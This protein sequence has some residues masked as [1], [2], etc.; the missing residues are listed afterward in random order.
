MATK[1]TGS[2]SFT[3][4][5][6]F[7]PK[8]FHGGL[9]FALLSIGY[10]S[11]CVSLLGDALQGN[12]I[13]VTAVENPSEP[14]G[15]SP[16][17]SVGVKK[18]ADSPVLQPARFEASQKQSTKI[19]QSSS[20]AKDANAASN[21]P[22]LERAP[23]PKR[24]APQRETL[25]ID[26]VTA[27][28]LVDTSNPTIA[29]ARARVVEAEQRLREVE[30]AWL[31][32]LQT[33]PAYV[34]HDGQ[35]QNSRGEV[36][37]VS[38]SNF[39]EGG[40][41]T[42]RWETANLYFGPLIAR[43]LVQAQDA[44]SRAVSSEIQL[45]VASAYLDLMRV[46]GTL[47]INTDTLARAGEMLN[48]AEAGEA[49]GKSKT[50]ADI[51]RA[52]T[53]VELRRQ[54]RI[55]IRG[56]AAVVSARLARLLLLEP[57]VDLR[58][59]DPKIVPVALLPDDSLIEEL[60]ATGLLNRP[61]L[62]ESRALVEAAVARWRQARVTPFVPRIEV[63][64]SGGLFGGGVNEVLSNFS[65]RSDGLAQAVWELHNL[66][67]GDITRA[68]QRR[69]QLTEASL[70]VRE[71][72]AQVAEEVTAAAKLV[73]TRREALDSSQKSV[74]EALETWRRLKEAS[75]GFGV[76]G[77]YDPLEPLLAEQALDQARNRYLTQVIEYN[78]AQFRLYWAMGQPPESALPKASALP[79][80]VP[81]VPGKP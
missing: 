75:F 78:R 31:P 1:Q 54:E 72:E 71:V 6:A 34:R 52:R 22:T 25:P 61:E 68:R 15:V 28:R 17:S 64:Y 58:P 42:L 13:L 26:L 65:G 32:D 10:S 46:Y 40:G 19:E 69:T 60:V 79:I 81:V 33:G 44:A 2:N 43:Q 37:G 5:S 62:A 23:A 30:V 35:L 76:G 50:P 66:G 57:T 11:G 80:N 14:V 41:A 63:T 67:A 24:G 45:E 74:T 55:E 36:F 27:L 48:S 12:N 16:I 49:A 18:R 73:E 38:K 77:K 56:Q 53:E 39:F 20:P 9:L 47:A 70:H 29:L 8:P 4:R 3:G 7:L 51:N 59:A 21:Q